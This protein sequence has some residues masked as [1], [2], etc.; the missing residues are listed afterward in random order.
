MSEPSSLPPAHI[1]PCGLYFYTL[2]IVRVLAK[3]VLSLDAV[4]VAGREHIPSSGGFIFASNHAS[5]FDP[6]IL[7]VASTR[8]MT[9]LAKIELFANPIFAR[10][11]RALGAHPV[12]RGKGDRE[13]FETAIALLHAGHGL[14]VFPEG[15]RTLTG[16]LGKIHAGAAMMALKARVPL[17]PAYIAGS[18]AAWPKRGRI[19]RAPVRVRIGAAL[20]MG[21]LADDTKSCRVLR[22]RLEEAIRNLELASGARGT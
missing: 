9:Y 14:V 20:P 21:D 6:P 10:A 18:F 11:I 15:T 16:K 5:Y 4:A 3:L 1:R 2:Q 7:A 19:R 17:V 12:E 13:A 22:A 8:Q